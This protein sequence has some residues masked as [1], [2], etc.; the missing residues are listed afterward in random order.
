MGLGVSTIADG[1]TAALIFLAMPFGLIAPKLLIEHFYSRTGNCR[2][3]VLTQR[4]RQND[5]Q[6]G[7]G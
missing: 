4:L 1:T 6:K 7:L 3:T 5:D 2:T